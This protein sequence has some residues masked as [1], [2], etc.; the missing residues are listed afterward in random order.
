[1]PRLII[2]AALVLALARPAA[3][4]PAEATE[5]VAAERAFAADAQALGIDGAFRRWSSEDAVTIA[6]AGPQRAHD[7]FASSK[8]T[9]SPPSTL[10]WW[11]NWAGIA[12][13][14]DLGFTTGAVEIAGARA[15]HYFTIWR[16][17]ADGSWKW[18]YDGG[19]D[20]TSASAPG[21][22]VE[23]VYLPTSVLAS[24]SPDTAM[25]EVR[26]VEAV[27]AAG[28]ARNQK[29]AHL[30]LLAPDG[31]LYVAALAPAIGEAAFATA[32]DAWPTRFDLSAPLGGGASDA[33]D[34]VWTYGRALWAG[35]A[36]PRSGYY[37]HLWQKRLRG[38]TLVF[39]QIVDDPPAPATPTPSPADD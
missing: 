10:V 32:L 22:E 23:P 7:L 9:P 14:G 11:P 16:R 6:G 20:A 12:K 31:R 30:A 28:A 17:Q 1:M 34:M 18:V 37:V 4:Q 15:G 27:L 38:W 13:S 39:A 19:V 35:D 5:I 8:K 2:L 21:P 26:T 29:D 33:G 25:S 24:T 3:A 36:G